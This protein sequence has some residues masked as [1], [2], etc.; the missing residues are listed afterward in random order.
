MLPP[1]ELSTQCIRCGRAL[2][3]EDQ[4]CPGCGANR[5]VELAIA[6]ELGPAIT[7]LRRW[8]LVLGL[9]MLLFAGLMY[10]ELQSLHATE[11]FSIVVLPQLV[12]AGILFVLSA[13]ARLIPF[14]ASLI[15]LLLF[16]ASWGLAIKE[17]WVAAF[18][19][20]LVLAVRLL[21]LVV[22][23]GAVQAGWRARRIRRRARE[24]FPTAVAREKR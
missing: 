7:T 8:L 6:A 23:V 4:I 9:I 1:K 5:E 24:S 10:S 19:P 22:L 20:G 2:G 18:A 15:A 3:T 21:F 13:V 16:A 11:L 17:D 12:A 14:A